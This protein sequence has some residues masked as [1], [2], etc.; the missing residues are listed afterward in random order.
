M[1]ISIFIFIFSTVVFYVSGSQYSQYE[2]SF[3]IFQAVKNNNTQLVQ[4][5][6]NKNQS[7]NIKDRDGQSLLHL[8]IEYGSTEIAELLIKSNVDLRAINDNCYSIYQWAEYYEKYNKKGILDLVKA[9]LKKNPID[10]AKKIIYIQALGKKQ[11]PKAALESA[12]KALKSYYNC[13]IKILPIE[14]LPAFAYYTTRKRYRAEK[15]L[16]YLNQKS[17]KD[18]YKVL[19]ITTVDISTTKG[20][21]PDWGIMGLAEVN[22]RAAVISYYRTGNKK[23]KTSSKLR[24]N[25]FAKVAVHE[26]GHT[27]GLL[28]CK[29]KYC[30]MAAYDGSRQF[31][32]RENQLCQD[33]CREFL[34]NESI[35]IEKEPKNFW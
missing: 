17:P 11:V 26:I 13:K 19:G 16:K 7:V 34:L 1:R 3:T 18:A 33:I 5:Y 10:L 15:L 25:R 22:A 12:V 30:L 8:A 29:H 35:I 32:D 23:S 9:A 28:H 20:K 31:L 27:L 24:I 6:I 14:K 2:S 21:Y 4:N